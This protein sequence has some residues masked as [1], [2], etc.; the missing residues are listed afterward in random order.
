[1]MTLV[2]RRLVFV[3]GELFINFPYISVKVEKIL[4]NG[5]TTTP[6][7]SQ[8]LGKKYETFIFIFLHCFY[9]QRPSHRKQIKIRRT[10][11]LSRVLRLIKSTVIVSLKNIICTVKS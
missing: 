11:Y 6:K 7:P 10:T 8:P 4:T 1:M 9:Q 5:K 3:Y 2:K